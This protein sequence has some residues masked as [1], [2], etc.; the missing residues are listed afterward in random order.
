M[1]L[2]KRPGVLIWFLEGLG[3]KKEMGCS[4]FRLGGNVGRERDRTT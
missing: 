3:L 2:E 4:G 1:E